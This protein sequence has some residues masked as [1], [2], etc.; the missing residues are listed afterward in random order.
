MVICDGLPAGALGT[1]RD[2]FGRGAQLLQRMAQFGELAADHHVEIA[3]QFVLGLVP[4][5][6]LRVDVFLVDFQVALFDQPLAKQGYIAAKLG[7]LVPGIRCRHDGVIV[8]VGKPAGGHAQHLHRADHAMANDQHGSRRRQAEQRQRG[9]ERQELAVAQ[10]SDAVRQRGGQ[11]I[12]GAAQKRGASVEQ[13]GCPA[14]IAAD[15]RNRSRSADRSLC[16][17]P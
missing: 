14:R 9:A 13:C 7:H 8:T 10:V 12:L 2:R 4:L 1:V 17:L 16:R 15:V 11:R 6:A 3:C 5:A